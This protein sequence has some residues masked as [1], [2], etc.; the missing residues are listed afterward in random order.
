[1]FLYRRI[2]SRA[3]LNLG[4]TLDTNGCVM[5]WHCLGNSLK[6][7]S[8]M[9]GEWLS[10]R[11]H[12]KCCPLISIWS[13]IFRLNDWWL[14]LRPWGATL[15]WRN[16]L[17]FGLLTLIKSEGSRRPF[18]TAGNN[19]GP[20]SI[21]SL[22]LPLPYPSSPL[23]PYLAHPLFLSHPTPPS[24]IPTPTPS[25]SLNTHR[26]LLSLLLFCPAL[27]FLLQNCQMALAAFTLM[28]CRNNSREPRR[29][30]I[31]LLQ[32]ALHQHRLLRKYQCYS[33]CAPHLHNMP[34]ERATE[35]RRKSQRRRSWRRVKMYVYCITW[36][37][38][39]I[40][41][42]SSPWLKDRPTALLRSGSHGSNTDPLLIYLWSHR[43]EHLLN[44]SC[45]AYFPWSFSCRASCGWY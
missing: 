22:A 9:A 25:L 12:G 44:I 20:Y 35:G 16:C 15:I 7:L 18:S 17:I 43:H 42:S 30:A 13:N 14:E 3:S 40:I 21:A 27:L 28:A 5:L 24:Y 32:L 23:C 37:R 6:T 38:S 19:R 34:C 41:F 39:L 36:S 31:L 8:K 29:S 45:S 33:R 11:V 1:M 4:E 10:H 2:G 26:S